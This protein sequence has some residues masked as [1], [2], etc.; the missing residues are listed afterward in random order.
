MIKH[1]DALKAI[2]NWEQQACFGCGAAN[3]HGLQMKFFTAN[4]RVYSFL[5]VPEA[6]MGSE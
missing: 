4:Q 5:E 2:P 1:P 6:M 3:E